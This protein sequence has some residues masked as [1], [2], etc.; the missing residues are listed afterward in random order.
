MVGV[1]TP[2]LAVSYLFIL[3]I[4]FNTDELAGGFVDLESGDTYGDP[5]DSGTGDEADDDD[6]EEDDDDDETDKGMCESCIT[7]CKTFYVCEP[8]A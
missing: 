6:N 8:Q 1:W 4:S 7:H 5:D 2:G 3:C